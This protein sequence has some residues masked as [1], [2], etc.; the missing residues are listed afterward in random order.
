MTISTRAWWRMLS[1][2]CG[3]LCLAQLM[4]CSAPAVLIRARAAAVFARSRLLKHDRMRLIEALA[5]NKPLV[6]V[7]L[8]ARPGMNEALV[9]EVRKLNGT[10]QYRDDDVDYLRVEIAPKGVQELSFSSAV[11][12]INLAGSVD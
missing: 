6:T 3:L 10:V 1:V 4:L 5:Q 9:A 12:S 8:A 7:L 2:I 11:E